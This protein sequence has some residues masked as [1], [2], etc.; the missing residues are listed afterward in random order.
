MSN[1]VITLTPDKAEPYGR[2]RA[3]G[4]QTASDLRKAQGTRPI[5]TH[6]LAASFKS[7]WGG[8]TTRIS[9]V[10][11]HT[12]NRDA[13]P[14]HLRTGLTKRTTHARYTIE[15]SGNQP[16][17]PIGKSEAPTTTTPKT[18]TQRNAEKSTARAIRQSRE[19][20]LL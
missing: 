11:P 1:D 9:K 12:P 20:G 8:H 17:I 19:R 10:E 4:E 13:L 5:W 3:P 16:A 7:F 2:G 14:A 15:V 6:G 18:R